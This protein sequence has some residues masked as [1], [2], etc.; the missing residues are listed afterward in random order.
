MFCE[1]IKS[2]HNFEN[3]QLLKIT[4]LIK[5]NCLNSGLENYYSIYTFDNK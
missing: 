4:E 2:S 1:H 3:K 5:I